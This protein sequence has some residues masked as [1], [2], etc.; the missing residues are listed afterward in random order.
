MQGVLCSRA[1]LSLF[2][3]Y[4]D[5]VS[6][7]EKRKEKIERERERENEK[8]ELRERRKKEKEGGKEKGRKGE[9]GRERQTNFLPGLVQNRGY[10]EL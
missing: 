8:E 4:S 7:M 3:L 1:Q 2:C 9:E 6:G 10:G 5:I